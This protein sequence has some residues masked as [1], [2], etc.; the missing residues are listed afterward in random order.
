MEETKETQFEI[1][2]AK[3]DKQ[4]AKIKARQD[5]LPWWRKC[6]A[7]VRILWKINRN[8]M[9][10]AMGLAARQARQLVE[11]SIGNVPPPK[12]VYPNLRDI[13]CHTGVGVKIESDRFAK[14]KVRV[15]VCADGMCVLRITAPMLEMDDSRE[16]GTYHGPQNGPDENTD[17]PYDWYVKHGDECPD[18]GTVHG[19]GEPHA[20]RG[21]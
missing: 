5:K 21:S 10:A 3:F 4:T 19:E 12:T 11:K 14:D 2:E 13:T 8:P 7:I 16:P 15:W 9:E 6:W 18:C 20:S 1:L 17:S